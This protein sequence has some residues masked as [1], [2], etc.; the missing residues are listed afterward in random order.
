M[1]IL[2]KPYIYSVTWKQG[3]GD[4]DLQTLTAVFENEG[5]GHYVRLI[6]DGWDMDGDEL[7]WLIKELK[8]RIAAADEVWDAAFPGGG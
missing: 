2:I 7:D 1:S 4:V 8:S 6:T 3:D 5:G